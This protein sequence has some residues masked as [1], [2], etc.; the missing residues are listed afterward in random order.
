MLVTGCWS[1]VAGRWSLVARRWLLV[2]DRWLLAGGGWVGDRQ[3]FERGGDRWRQ[4]NPTLTLRA[5][6]H[7]RLTGARR[8][9]RLDVR[10]G[11][12]LRGRRCSRRNGAR[13][14]RRALAVEAVIEIGQSLKESRI[15]GERPPRICIVHAH[16]YTRCPSW[17]EMEQ[18]VFKRRKTRNSFDL[19]AVP[20][21]EEFDARVLSAMRTQSALDAPANYPSNALCVV[22]LPRPCAMESEL[23]THSRL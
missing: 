21:L 14:R 12:R 18:G 10:R 2:T 22:H 11:S 5:H 23:L 9:R 3:R 7:R 15:V 20:P 19:N 8:C 1:R 4:R 16:S 6:A 17:V 13:R